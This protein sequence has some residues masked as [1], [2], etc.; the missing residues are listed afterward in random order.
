M[1]QHGMGDSRG[2]RVKVAITAW[3][4][5]MQE[6]LHIHVRGLNM[7]QGSAALRMDGEPGVIVLYHVL[8][9]YSV[10]TYNQNRETE[11]CCESEVFQPGNVI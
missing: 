6:A 8:Y 11:R 4:G 9:M 5:G 3:G 10:H 7:I 1:E 2:L